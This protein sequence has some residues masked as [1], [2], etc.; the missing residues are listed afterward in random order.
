M[1][2]NSLAAAA[3]DVTLQ[4]ICHEGGS[5][6][7]LD[8]R[9]IHLETIYSDIKDSSNG[10][11]TSS[12]AS[13]QQHY[14]TSDC[15]APNSTSPGS[16]YTCNTTSSSNSSCSTF[17]FFRATRQ[18]RTLA[19]ISELLNSS[20]DSMQHL[21]GGVASSMEVLDPGREVVVPVQCSCSGQYFQ[22]ELVTYTAH[23]NNTSVADVACSVFESLVTYS[24]IM[25][26]NGFDTDQVV[27]GTVIH[28]P[29]KC[30]CPDLRDDNSTNGGLNYL[31]TYPVFEGDM[32]REIDDKFGISGEDLFRINGLDPWT[33]IYPN[34]TLLIPLKEI[35]VRVNMTSRVSS[36]PPPAPVFLPTIIVERRSSSNNSR[37][38]RSFYITGS[39]IVFF[40]SVAAMFAFGMHMN[41]RR[42]EKIQKLLSFNTSISQLTCSTPK[43]SATGLTPCLSPDLLVGIKYSLRSYSTDELRIGTKDFSDENKIGDEG[44]KALID[45]VE[46]MVKP[47]MFD[48][49][50]QVVDIHSRINH[51]NIV[52]LLG[53]CYDHGD[54]SCIV[55]ELPSNGCLRNCLANPSSHLRWNRRTQIAFDVATGLHY[56]HYCI[57][58]SYAHMSV[59][60]RNIFL[61]SNW[62]A[63]LTNIRTNPSSGHSPSHKGWLA[64]EYNGSASDKVDIFA[65]GV[66]LLELISGREDTDGTSFKES[67]GFLGGGAGEG[68]CFERLRSF[69]DPCLEG[70]YP[71]AEALCL[72]VLAKACVED[73][74]LHR[75]SMDDILKVLVRMV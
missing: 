71:L 24:T 61:T 18:F 6:E 31:A 72:S 9:K 10:R 7:L 1:T 28:L 15:A 70:N 52:A 4:A 12:K 37:L 56:L 45:D 51:I 13:A 43:S 34:T 47:M 29:L 50:R 63:K 42:K 2:P 64:P 19:S 40:I 20:V 59:N 35:S 75:P 68:G 17:L 25:E 48:D 16:R 39:V 3:G 32:L 38:K 54:D 66:V 33:T 74:P 49:I 27:A 62:R 65:F 55:L 44:Y 69:V 58:P 23:L 46:V 60:T 14:D 30:A 67:L 73:D 41:G 36:S 57:F 22:T 5:L 21:N 26:A 8:Q 11:F 53:V